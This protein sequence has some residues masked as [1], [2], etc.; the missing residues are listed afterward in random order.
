M[1]ASLRFLH[2]LA[3]VV[4]IGGIVFFSFFTAPA[5]FGVLPRDMAGRVTAVLFPRYYLLGGTCGAIALLTSVWQGWRAPARDRGRR[6]ETLLLLLMLA[7][8]LYAGLG[9]LP[10]TSSLLSQL[11]AADDTAGRQ[12]AQRR[13]DDLHRRSVLLNGMV[14]VCGIGTLAA[15]AWRDSRLSVSA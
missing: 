14:L 15:L 12:A 4:W 10:E 8:T 2:L 5:L 3:L 9:I 11:H 13:F 1:A 7:M 6:I